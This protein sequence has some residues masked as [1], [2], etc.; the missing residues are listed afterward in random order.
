MHQFFKVVRRFFRGFRLRSKL[1]GH[2]FYMAGCCFS[3]NA[4][5]N[6][7]ES[8]IP[9]NWCVRPG[10]WSGN[11][12][13]PVAK[14]HPQNRIAKAANCG[15]AK[16]LGWSHAP[17]LDVAT[18]GRTPVGKNFQFTLSELSKGSV[19][20]QP[21]PQILAKWVGLAPRTLQRHMKPLMALGAIV[22]K[23][24]RRA[25]ASTYLLIEANRVEQIKDCKGVRHTQPLDRSGGRA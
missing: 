5:T 21:T 16:P 9:S 10:L 2:T 17:P 1:C 6:R 13:N 25:W 4:K 20:C 15:H 8:I 11:R 22:H 24:G 7:R 23:V 12:A 18:A 3:A 14:L 19:R